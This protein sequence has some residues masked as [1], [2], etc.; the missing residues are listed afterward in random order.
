MYLHVFVEMPTQPEDLT[1]L[2]AF[3]RFLCRMYGDVVPQILQLNEPLA[4]DCTFVFLL[5]SMQGL[6]ATHARQ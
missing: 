1:T 2:L 4:T 3:E 6:V 5:P